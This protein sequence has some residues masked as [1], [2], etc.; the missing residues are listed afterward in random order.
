MQIPKGICMYLH[1][2][3]VQVPH[4]P[5]LATGHFWVQVPHI[6][7]LATGQVGCKYP[8]YPNWRLAPEMGALPDVVLFLTTLSPP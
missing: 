2:S 5:K 8:T 1:L 7:K 3:G 6:P 4:I